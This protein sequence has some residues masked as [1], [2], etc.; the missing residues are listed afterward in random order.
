ML[1]GTIINSLLILVGGGIGL[2]V[3]KILPARLKDSAMQAVSLVVM[4][5][6][7]SGAVSACLTF[8]NGVFGTKD[9]LIMILS[10]VLGTILGELI[11]I[12]RHLDNLGSFCRKK[13]IRENDTSSFA[14]G[15]V[16]ATLLFCVGAMA[17]VGALDNGIRGNYDIL[18]AK[19][20]IDCIAALILA[21]TLGAGVLLAAV[22]VFLYQ[23]LISLI[24]VYIEPFLTEAVIS[25]MTL[26][27]SILIFGIGI[28]MLNIVRLRLGNMLPA[29]FMPIILDLILRLVEKITG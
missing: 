13:L 29:V 24:G 14:E 6:G 3:K 1:T 9:T 18:L 17:V 5:I 23:G 15:I 28:K 25:Q 19:A 27:G 4:F 22:P 2:L 8:Q 26:T 11:N 10:L 12:E 16:T 20:V 7:I 21:S